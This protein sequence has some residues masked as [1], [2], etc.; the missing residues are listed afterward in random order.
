[1]LDLNVK[2]YADKHPQLDFSHSVYRGCRV[3]MTAICPTHG[4]VTKTPA[5]WNVNG[6]P[7]CGREK[8][9]NL[10]VEKAQK[11][12]SGLR[13]FTATKNEKTKQE[14]QEW[15]NTVSD[16]ILV[17]TEYEKDTTPIKLKCL[18]HAVEFETS[19][20][21]ARRGKLVC[22]VCLSERLKTARKAKPEVLKAH[23]YAAHGDKY[24][25]SKT[26]FSSGRHVSVIITCKKHGDFWQ[27][28][29]N[30]ING[31]GC[32]SC[33][34]V[35]SKP[36]NE[37]F[38]FIR[39]L[40][41][42]AFQRNRTI[43]A[44]KELD[45]YI[46]T[47]SLA[48]E[49]NGLNWYADDKGGTSLKM[50]HLL[51]K[52]K[53]IRV[54]HVFADEWFYKEALIKQLLVRTLTEQKG[55][56]GRKCVV[57]PI[58]SPEARVFM[59]KTHLQGFVGGAHYGLFYENELVAALTM[60]KARFENK[61]AWEVARF[62]SSKKVVGAFAKLFSFFK[63]EKCPQKVISYADLRFGTGNVYATAGFVLTG[64]TD[65][66]YW[67]FNRNERLSR[68]QTQKHKLALDERFKQY[69][70]DDKTETEMCVA[71]GYR[72]ITGVGHNKW[73]WVAPQ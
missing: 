48:V 71:A 23:C 61:S 24:D 5:H 50:K 64:T 26:D 21:T 31:C 58:T 41:V 62:S 38:S 40:G 29:H 70:S 44:P 67:W 28:L 16:T 14:F 69:Y 60:V 65:P 46:P 17:L 7:S 35:V 1:M 10:S 57:R 54:I 34:N 8:G 20:K 59:E 32:P 72:R 12:F 9:R 47:L 49:L 42:E 6:C 55:L 30:H 25:Y 45:I 4:P 68:Y 53:G 33:R 11:K 2:R 19:F 73:V 66:D 52:E 39:S 3:L 43:I 18:K 51:A 56:Q 37:L 13:S 22:P 36:E 27:Y 15:R 63:T